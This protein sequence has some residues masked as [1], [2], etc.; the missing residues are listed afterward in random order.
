MLESK[1]LELVIRMVNE[2]HDARWLQ[3]QM[4]ELQ[5][6]FWDIVAAVKLTADEDYPHEIKRTTLA[7]FE[8][9]LRTALQ[10]ASGRDRVTIQMILSNASCGVAK[11]E[12]KGA[13]KGTL[14]TNAAIGY[15]DLVDIHED[16]KGLYHGAS[17]MLY[18][19]LL[20]SGLERGSEEW[21]IASFYLGKCT[22]GQAK[23][24]DSDPKL[25]RQAIRILI[26]AREEGMPKW[27]WIW[28]ESLELQAEAHGLLADKDEDKAENQF[29]MDAL[30]QRAMT[31]ATMPEPITPEMFDQV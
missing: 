12:P 26:S 6:G 29:M 5:P 27:N 17:Q 9:T 13:S 25:L 4:Q 14:L 16:P 7:V 28:A 1:S 20:G 18:Q 23:A 8:S 2:G 30:K 15:L 31:E 3:Q 21:Y 11:G 22:L 19:A 24:F 10:Q